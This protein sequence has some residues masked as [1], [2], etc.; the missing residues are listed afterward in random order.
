LLE[1]Q[2]SLS[3]FLPLP[4]PC[5][6]C[7]PAHKDVLYQPPLSQRNIPHTDY[8]CSVLSNPQV[9]I[10]FDPPET[11][12]SYTYRREKAGVTGCTGVGRVAHVVT[13]VPYG[14]SGV[15]VLRTLDAFGQD[16]E[17][18]REKENEKDIRSCLDP[19]ALCSITDVILYCTDAYSR[20][21]H[22]L[23]MSPSAYLYD[24]NAD[25]SSAIVPIV[26]PWS[27][28]G[29]LGALA[30]ASLL[31]LPSTTTSPSSSVLDRSR[32]LGSAKS[33]SSPISTTAHMARPA[34]RSGAP[35]SASALLTSHSNSEVLCIVSPDI[36]AFEGRQEQMMSYTSPTGVTIDSNF[37]SQTLRQVIS[38]S[39]SVLF[40]FAPSCH[41]SICVHCSGLPSR[42]IHC[43]PSFLIPQYS[44]IHNLTPPLRLPTFTPY[45]APHYTPLPYTAL[46]ST[47]PPCP[48]TRVQ[49]PSSP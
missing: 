42:I 49:S 28:E 14:R 10:N 25:S 34:S 15:E 40:F 35:V 39:C 13:L 2:S 29:Y 32:P 21:I 7:C 12:E 37:A 9:V 11:I 19:S 46:Y 18:E 8:S 1:R 48:T 22:G 3:P 43:T 26:E 41:D 45:P 27:N 33:R 36:A 30:D 5:P 47:A 4:C 23:S 17:I 38:H 6:S 20:S 24:T 16:C 31:R 44:A